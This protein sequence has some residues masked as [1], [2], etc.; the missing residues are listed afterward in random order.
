M[1]LYF[2]YLIVNIFYSVFRVPFIKELGTR[3]GTLLLINIITSY[4][5]YRLVLDLIIV[6]FL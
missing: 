3:T 1:L 2:L 4:F 6:G 5:S